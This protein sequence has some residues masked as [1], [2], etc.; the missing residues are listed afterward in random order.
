MEI[1]K[2]KIDPKKLTGRVL[3]D[4]LMDGGLKGLIFLQSSRD[5][6]INSNHNAFV[7]KEYHHEGKVKICFIDENKQPVKYSPEEWIGIEKIMDCAE[8]NL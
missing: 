8:Y 1:D 6:I 5:I 2:K 4:C 3:G 7:V